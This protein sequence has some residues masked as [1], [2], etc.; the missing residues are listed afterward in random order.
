VCS[1]RDRRIARIGEAID[2]VATAM[3]GA[4]LTSAEMDDLA[5]RVADI[6]AMVAEIDPAL[7]V[8]LPGYC[9]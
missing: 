2:E 7:A 9:E 8:R 1:T 5:G 6:W 4:T 3:R